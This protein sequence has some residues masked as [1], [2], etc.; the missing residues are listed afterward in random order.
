ML[1]MEIRHGLAEAF[2]YRPLTAS[3]GG[4]AVPLGPNGELRVVSHPARRTR[5]ISS[6]RRM[7]LSSGVAADKARVGVVSSSAGS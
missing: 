2:C 6:I 1:I 5:V 4:S 3:G 7:G